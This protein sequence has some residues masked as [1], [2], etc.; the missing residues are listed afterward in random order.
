MSQPHCVRKRGEFHAPTGQPINGFPCN[1]QLHMLVFL[2]Q[3][4]T[5]LLITCASW[6]GRT[7]EAFT[8]KSTQSILEKQ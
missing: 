6:T 2:V 5:L 4:S 8:A 7:Q 3:L 1:A